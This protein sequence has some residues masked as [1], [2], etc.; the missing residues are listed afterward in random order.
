MTKE[1]TGVRH[2]I[3]QVAFQTLFQLNSNETIEQNDAIQFALLKDE[4][5]QNKD[6]TIE[7][8]IQTGLPQKYRNEDII[9]DSA[10]FL[11]ELLEGIRD[12]QAQIDQVIDENMS[13]WNVERIHLTHLTILRIAAYE[14]LFMPETDPRIV[15][16]EAIELS[17][18]F[19]DEKSRKFINGV[20]QGIQNSKKEA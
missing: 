11:S 7:E 20:L 17:K 5:T 15:M 16:N 12:H 2:F 8:M 3:R 10:I 6:L 1:I 14:L 4:A 13:A 18:E 19:S 9:H